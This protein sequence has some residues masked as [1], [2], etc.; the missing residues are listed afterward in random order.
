MAKQRWTEKDLEQRG[1]YKLSDGSYGRMIE[2]EVRFRNNPADLYT[3]DE[4]TE[5]DGK[6]VKFKQ[7]VDSFTHLGIHASPLVV[8]NIEPMGAV[9]MTKSDTWK[10]DPFHKDPRKRQRKPVTRYFKFKRELIL[11]AALHGFKL[12]EC[13]FHV[14]FIIPMAMSWSDKKKNQMDGAPHKQRPD[15]DNLI[16]AVK[17]SLCDEDAHIWDYRI[18]KRWGRSGKIVIYP[19]K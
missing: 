1:L 9:R 4:L 16:K 17:D 10:L 19:I 14:F 12:P 3:K 5:L 8:F 2:G 6:E 7:Q 13:D 18:T 15:T 11:Q